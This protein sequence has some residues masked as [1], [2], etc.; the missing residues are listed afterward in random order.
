MNTKWRFNTSSTDVLAVLATGIK[1]YPLVSI[2]QYG[3]TRTH[4]TDGKKFQFINTS[5]GNDFNLVK[6]HPCE[7]LTPGDLIMVWQNNQAIETAVLRT[8]AGIHKDGTSVDIQYLKNSYGPFLPTWQ[9]ALPLD[10][11]TV[12]IL[13][14]EE[15]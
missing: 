12:K 3:L 13:N 8:L 4:D 7:L 6:R 10:D 1:K 5:E 9:N 15:T 14:T 2:D 11:W